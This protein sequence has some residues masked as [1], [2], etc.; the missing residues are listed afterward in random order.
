V[1]K[2]YELERSSTMPIS[3]Y[4]SSQISTYAEEVNGIRAQGSVHFSSS[5]VRRQDRGKAYYNN[6][7]TLKRSVS[8]RVYL[9][10]GESPE[11]RPVAEYHSNIEIWIIAVS[12]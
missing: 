10:K 1:A 3:L 12:H 4:T 9:G 8:T 5:I 2:L 11:D 7:G 6:I